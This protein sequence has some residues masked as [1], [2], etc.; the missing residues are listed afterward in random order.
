MSIRF[1]PLHGPKFYDLSVEATAG[2]GS[3]LPGAANEDFYRITLTG[4]SDVL[5]RT[6]LPSAAATLFEADNIVFSGTLVLAGRGQGVVFAAGS[7]SQFGRVSLLTTEV[8]RTLSPL[9]QE[10][11]KR[12]TLDVFRKGVSDY[13]SRFNLVY[14]TQIIYKT[15]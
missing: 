4:E 3:V 5:T 14:F 2:V 13:G 6:A 11:E 1:V 12:G 8:K 9:E 15:Q 7:K 10:I